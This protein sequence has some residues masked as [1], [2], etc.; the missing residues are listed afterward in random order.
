MVEIGRALPV[1]VFTD[2]GM[3]LLRRNQPITSGQHLEKLRSFGG[4]ITEADALA[5][6][7]AYERMVH[8]MMVS[9]VDVQ[10]IA[11]APMPA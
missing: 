6:Q 2:T 5:W 9:G 4:S 11:R 7:H 1:D 3:L 8:E 10:M